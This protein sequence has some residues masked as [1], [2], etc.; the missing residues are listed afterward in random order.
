MK[1][2]TN[3][4]IIAASVVMAALILGVFFKYRSNPHGNVHVIGKAERDFESDLIVWEGDFMRES[5]NLQEAYTALNNDRE[6]TKRYL[7]E[8]GVQEKDIVFSAVGIER[9]YSKPD[10]YEGSEGKQSKNFQGF[11]LV[12]TVVIESKEIDKIETISREVTE[13]INQGVEFNSKAPSYYYTKLAELKIEMIA[14]AT[15]DAKV[16]AETIAKNTCS[17]LGRTEDADMGVF[18]ITGRNSSEDKY[19]WGGS[20]NTTARRKTASIT[21]RLNCQLN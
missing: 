10:Y 4:L 19:E 7:T 5:M 9:L 1:H 20:Y 3:T 18:Q 8:K 21:M 6:T 17:T 11:R 13:L 12:Q 14:A 15:Q 2:Y 16:R